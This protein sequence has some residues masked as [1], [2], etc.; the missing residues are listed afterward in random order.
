M[1]GWGKEGINRC[2]KTCSWDNVPF[3]SL[4][5]YFAP[6][7]MTSR[8]VH[9]RLWST[10]HAYP[11][12]CSGWPA[13]QHQPNRPEKRWSA[14]NL[15]WCRVIV[16]ILLFCRFLMCD[17]CLSYWGFSGFL[18]LWLHRSQIWNRI[19]LTV[20]LQQSSSFRR[21]DNVQI[22]LHMFQIGVQLI[23]S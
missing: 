7:N 13:V 21:A 20:R 5:S 3:K 4:T 23:V 6:G 1:A 12:L 17:T 9:T 2:K 16:M 14:L 22:C 19:R 11:A 8:Q 10:F 18:V 15:W